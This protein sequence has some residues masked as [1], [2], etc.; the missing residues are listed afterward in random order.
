MTP[1]VTR[2]DH[3]QIAEVP[4]RCNWVQLAEG[5]LDSAHI[6]HLHASASANGLARLAQTRA[7]HDDLLAAHLHQRTQCAH[8]RERRGGVG[9]VQVALDADRL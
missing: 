6:S 4:G 2:I 3:I 5:Q 9:R 8:R 7:T 1:R